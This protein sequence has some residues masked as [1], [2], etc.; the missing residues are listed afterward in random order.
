[1]LT[2]FLRESDVCN[3]VGLSKSTIRKLEMEGKFPS[4]RKLTGDDGQA[5]A[6]RE[7]EIDKWI[8]TRPT[9]SHAA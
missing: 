2:R 6:W 5:V 4:K 3:I 1:M 8:K 9:C 7:D